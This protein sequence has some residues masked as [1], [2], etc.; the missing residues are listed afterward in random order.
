MKV[1]G[2]LILSVVLLS[3]TTVA[4]AE[5]PESMEPKLEQK[6]TWIK[7]EKGSIEMFIDGKETH[8]RIQRSFSKDTEPF[9]LVDPDNRIT[10]CEMG[11]GYCK[12]QA[13]Q[14]WSDLQEFNYTKAKGETK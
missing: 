14:K 12:E 1:K 5:K 6:E 9:R 7:S 4:K 8:F 13:K 3:L 10:E 2:L 11:I